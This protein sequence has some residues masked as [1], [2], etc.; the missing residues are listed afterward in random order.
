MAAWAR[1]VVVVTVFIMATACDTKVIEP[2]ATT[3]MPRRDINEVLAAHDEQ[4]MAIPG[5]V[6]VYVGLLEDDQTSC[7]R[8]MVA[9]KAA[10]LQQALPE[11]LEGYPVVLEETGVIRPLGEQ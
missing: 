6:G 8:V 3:P 7:L 4:M 10:E 9:K 2:E 1:F 11:S 5:V